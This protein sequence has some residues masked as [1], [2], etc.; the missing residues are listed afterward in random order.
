M[1]CTDFCPEIFS[2]I[3]NRPEIIFLINIVQPPKVIATTALDAD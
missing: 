1:F 3:G 2:H